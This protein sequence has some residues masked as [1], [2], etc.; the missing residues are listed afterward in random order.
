MARGATPTEIM[1]SIPPGRG[2][3]PRVCPLDHR[4]AARVAEQAGRLLVQVR[5]EGSNQNMSPHALGQRADRLAN[6]L[7]LDQLAE[8]C[9]GDAVL[10]EESPDDSRRLVADRVWIIDPLDGTREFRQPGRWDWAVH[11]ALVEAGRPTAAAVALPALGLVLAT[12]PSGL[13]RTPTGPSGTPVGDMAR[14]G[15]PAGDTAGPGG[16]AGTGRPDPPVGDTSTAGPYR[17]LLAPRATPGRLR[18]VL[19]SSRPP[20][21]GRAIQSA[22]DAEV[23]LL[24]S[25]GAKAMA[26]VLGQAEVYAHTGGQHE[27]DSAAPVGVAVAAGLHASRLDG[28]SLVYNRPDTWVPDLLICRPELA[29]HV[30][31]AAAEWGG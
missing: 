8:A 31:R 1:P 28:S 2:T 5:Q 16:L 19:S 29:N 26:V 27:W 21:V 24:G 12:S 22:L 20:L 3:L 30:V 11:V 13:V 9:P 15:G 4:T 18:L 7:I 6:Q 14:S 23:V 10:S 25:A 17:Q